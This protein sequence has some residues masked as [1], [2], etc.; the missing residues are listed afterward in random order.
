MKEPSK[1]YSAVHEHLRV[2]HPK[3]GE[4]QK[5]HARRHTEYA[6]IH[7]KTYSR[8]RLDYLE[9]CVPCHRRYDGNLPPVMQGEDAPGSKLT[10]EIVIE[11]RALYRRGESGR[12][13][14]SK[15]KVSKSG[16]QAA[17]NRET[18]RHVL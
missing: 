18:W 10:E 3:S 5:C 17:I 11:A 15:Y 12:S 13:L 6:L 14:A 8:N 1:T 9:L 2:H 16:M 7:G 4:C